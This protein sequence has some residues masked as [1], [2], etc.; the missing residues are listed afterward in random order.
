MCVCVK[1]GAVRIGYRNLLLRF[2]HLQLPCGDFYVRIRNIRNV[3]HYCT[4]IKITTR[5]QFV[6]LYT[7]K[8][9]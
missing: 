5:F 6:L 4:I 8:P 7:I 1:R 3:C 9:I 2:T